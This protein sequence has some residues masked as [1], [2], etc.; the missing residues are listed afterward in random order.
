M[1]T[2]VYMCVLIPVALY[3]LVKDR[4][5]E[6]RDHGKRGSEA[7]RGSGRYGG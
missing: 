7:V 6:K 2:G 4:E 5:I 1:E 3:N